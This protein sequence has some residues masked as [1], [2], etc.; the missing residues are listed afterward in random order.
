MAEFTVEVHLT[1]VII[2]KG[3]DTPEEAE[4]LVMDAP[5]SLAGKPMFGVRKYVECRDRVAV[6]IQPDNVRTN[7]RS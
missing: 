1:G 6:E 2:V 3:V 5:A 7:L 4:A